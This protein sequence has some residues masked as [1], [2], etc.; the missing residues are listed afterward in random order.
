MLQKSTSKL[1]IAENHSNVTKPANLV[2]QDV[3][4]R[5]TPEK[6]L[7]LLLLLSLTLD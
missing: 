5:L 1:L 3:H 6:L 2:R 4:K 7:E